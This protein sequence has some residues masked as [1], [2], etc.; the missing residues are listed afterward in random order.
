MNKKLLLASTTVSGLALAGPTLAADLPVKAPP[1]VAAPAFT[2]TGCHIGAQVGGARGQKEWS[3]FSESLFSNLFGGAP[4]T[5]IVPGTST[6]TVSVGVGTETRT[7]IVHVKQTVSFFPAGKPTSPGGTESH[8]VN[9]TEVVTI[10]VT[11]TGT[12]TATV[13]VTAAATVGGTTNRI[14]SISDDTAGF[15]AG[16]QVGCDLQFAPRWVVGIEGDGEWAHITGTTDVAFSGAADDIKF[17]VIPNMFASAHTRTEWLASVTA[18]VGYTPWDRWLLYVKGGAAWAGDKYSLGGSACT[19]VDTTSP[20]PVCAQS[21]PFAF[22]A[23]ETRFGWTTGV[24][25]EYAFWDTWSARLEYDFYDFGTR[26]VTFTD[27]F[28]NL[29]PGGADINQRLN[30]IKFGVNYRFG[31]GKTP[32]PVT[33]RY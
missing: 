17:P 15:L 22:G 6:Q 23:S 9:F 31:W 2:W 32:F 8:V 33:A 5:A 1:I 25:I 10:S 29:G 19:L 27:A 13:S 3:D 11:G 24:G 7:E 16:G 14:T 12:G 18:R 21:F 20:P 26:H 4:F 30:V 28:G